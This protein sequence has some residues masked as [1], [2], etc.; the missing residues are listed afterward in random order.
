MKEKMK[1]ISGIAGLSAIA[2]VLAAGAVFAQDA[3]PT[4][5]KGDTTWMMISTILVLMMTVPGLALFYGGLVRAKNML[6]MLTQVFVITCVMM[7]LWVVFGYSVALNPGGSMDAFFGGGSRL[8][9]KG[10]TPD[11]TVAT[12]TDGVEIPEYIF[13]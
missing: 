3:G 4:V 7:I 8:F 10:V 5:D 1:R 12:F 9:L 6:S 11:S 13:I 2:S